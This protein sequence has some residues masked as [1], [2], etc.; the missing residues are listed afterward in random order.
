LEDAGHDRA[1]WLWE[2]AGDPEGIGADI[3]LRHK[4]LR[5]AV[6]R[7]DTAQQE[8]R[9]AMRDQRLNLL[10]VQK[11]LTHAISM[12]RTRLVA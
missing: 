2:V 5:R 6:F 4:T 8:K 10:L 12:L 7:N 1:D 11:R 9:R 3:K